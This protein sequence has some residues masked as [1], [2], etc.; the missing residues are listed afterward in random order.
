MPQTASGK[1][2]MWAVIAI[3]VGLAFILFIAYFVVAP[4]PSY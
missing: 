1:L 4:Q 2:S 3:L